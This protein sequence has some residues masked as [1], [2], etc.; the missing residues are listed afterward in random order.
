MVLLA[1]TN[2]IYNLNN[3]NYYYIYNY[4]YIYI[5]YIYIYI[6]YTHLISSMCIVSSLIIIN[7]IIIILH[8]N[9]FAVLF[10][11]ECVVDTHCSYDKIIILLYGRIHT[12]NLNCV[13]V[14][15]LIKQYNYYQG[16]YSIYSKIENHNRPV[17]R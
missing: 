6:Y 15:T 8:K 14:Y 13:T 7:I 10:Y 11:S 9:N 2:L 16:I 3:Y 5:L 1:V 12:L 4:I 17:G